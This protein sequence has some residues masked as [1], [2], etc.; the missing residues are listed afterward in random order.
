MKPPI[1]ATCAALAVTLALRAAPDGTPEYAV[2][3]AYVFNFVRFVDWPPAEPVRPL[4]ICVAGKS[5]ITGFLEEAVRGKSV[6]GAPVVVYRVSERSESWEVCS[7]VFVPA[8]DRARTRGV[9]ERVRGLNVLTIGESSEFADG[10]GMLTLAVDGQRTRFSVNL[11]AVA[12]TRLTISSKLVEL[13]RIVRAT[14]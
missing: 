8:M 1:A 2:K 12:G 4:A 5:P 13:G 7:A 11:D 10:G 3:A 14:R 9:L 6:H